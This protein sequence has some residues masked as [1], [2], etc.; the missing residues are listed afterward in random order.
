MQKLSTI[1]G[2]LAIPAIGFAFANLS[3]AQG[4]PLPVE[5]LPLGKDIG[6]QSGQT[7]TPAYEG[8]YE[9]PDGNIALSFG[10]YNRNTEQVL[11]IPVGP[12]NRII[13]AA[14]GSPNQGQPTRFETERHWGVFTVVVP[15]DYQEQVVWHLENQGKTFHI[16]ANRK[17]EYVID[18]IAGDANGNYPPQIKFTENGPTGQGPAGVT[19][20]TLQAKVGEPLTVN[21]Y[22]SDDGAGS[23]LAAM[24]LGGGNAKPPVTLTWLKQQGPGK[25]M[26]SESTA[27]IPVDGAWTSTEVTFD[28]PGDYLLRARLNEFTGMEMAG[29][30]QCCWTNGFVKVSVSN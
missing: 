14:D 13:G 28:K 12:A 1:L 11:E 17:N 21:A 23:G 20:D 30:A 16:P 25:V 19:S 8:W 3:L 7:V 27:R 4:V 22:V 2:K 15:A 18:A 24:F 10:Y 6:I 5:L 29:H 9:L 26:F